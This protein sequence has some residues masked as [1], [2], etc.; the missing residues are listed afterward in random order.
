MEWRPRESRLRHRVLMPGCPDDSYDRSLDLPALHQH[1]RRRAREPRP[2]HQRRTFTAPSLDP[3]SRVGSDLLAFTPESWPEVGPPTARCN[4]SSPRRET[5]QDPKKGDRIVAR[6][7]NRKR[8]LTERVGRRATDR[9][10][11]PGCRFETFDS[12]RSGGSAMKPGAVANPRTAWGRVPRWHLPC[13][14]F[15]VGPDSNEPSRRGR[16]LWAFSGG[17]SS[18]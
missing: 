11:G 5:L 10:V 15:L 3:G 2:H 4:S 9:R 12:P 1:C 17:S 7:P 13:S 8:W 6:P 14:V 18:G 16:T